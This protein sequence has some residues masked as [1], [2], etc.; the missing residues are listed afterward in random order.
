MQGDG[1][2]IEDLWPFNEEATAN[3]IFNSKIPIIS[4]VGHETDFTISDF[5]A[6]LRAP[7]PSAAAELAIPNVEDIKYKIS[8]YKRRMNISLEKKLEYMKIQYKKVI[9]SKVF[10]APMQRVN[11]E[12]LKVDK[13]IQNLTN[14]TNT[15]IKDN[16]IKLV[17]TVS[18]LDALS[19]LKTLS[20]GYSIVET[21]GKI[22]KKSKDLNTGDEIILKFYDGTKSAKIL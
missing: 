19:P 11:D 14:L 21:K 15:K 22:I 6:D 10:T 20:R 2:S 13:L 16:K 5:V 3:A 17:E 7:T 1:G 4:A 8:T 12:Y 18:K 9:A